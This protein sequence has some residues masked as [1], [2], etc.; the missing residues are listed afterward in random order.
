M[1]LN[2]SKNHQTHFIWR[3]SIGILLVGLIQWIGQWWIREPSERFWMF[4]PGYIWLL[5]YY[6]QVIPKPELPRQSLWTRWL[7]LIILWSFPVAFYVGLVTLCQSPFSWR[8]LLIVVYFFVFCIE[9]PLLYFFNGLDYLDAR[10]KSR[11]NKYWGAIGRVLLRG[12]AYLILIPVLLTIFG[13][14]RPKLLPAGFQFADPAFVEA[15]EFESREENPLVLRGEYLTHPAAKGSVIVCHGVGANRSD[16]SAIVEL[17]YESEYN[18][19]TFDF[20]GHGESDGHTITYGTRERRDVQGAY[21]YLLSHP[22][23]DPNKLYAL[24]V[25]MGGSALL[26]ALPEMPLV[27]AAIVDSSFAD[28]NLMVH[29]QLKYFPEWIRVGMVSLTRL[30][31]WMETGADLTAMCPLDFICEINCPVTI[32]HGQA[33]HI[34]PFEQSEL[35]KANCKHLKDYYA[36]EDVDHIGTAMLQPWKY[37]ELIREAFQNDE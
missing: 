33:D 24:G 36:P 7:M 6:L 2:E 4:L 1:I 17:V 16:I 12:C 21:D 25:S 26:L 11:L 13:I 29:H 14:H 37:Q 27:Q 34:V 10:L 32:I 19:L 15:V 31:G 22:D 3:W 8:E 28:L 9:I 5:A 23:T 30:V 20:R 18:V 35:L